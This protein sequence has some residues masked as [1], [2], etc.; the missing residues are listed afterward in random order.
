MIF[1]IWF[2]VITWKL[3]EKTSEQELCTTTRLVCTHTHI[4]T[5]TI[6]CTHSCFTITFLLLSGRHRDNLWSRWHHNRDRYGGWGLVERFWSGRTLWHVPRKLRG[7]SLAP[8]V[9]LMFTFEKMET[10]QVSDENNYLCISHQ[11][12]YVCQIKGLLIFYLN[13][14]LTS[15]KLTTSHFFM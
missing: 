11:S 8:I 14:C 10:S 9:V 13:V 2:R 12:L 3:Q 7:A 6:F 5:Y 1:Q 15:L 4:Y